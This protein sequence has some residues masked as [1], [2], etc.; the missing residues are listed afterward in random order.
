MLNG[1]DNSLFGNINNNIENK[2]TCGSDSYPKSKDKNVGLIN[3][4]HVS[5]QLTGNTPGKDEGAL[6]QVNREDEQ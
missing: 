5:K 1:S 2:M 3:N 6:K 4:Y